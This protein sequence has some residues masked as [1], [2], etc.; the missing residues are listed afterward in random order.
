MQAGS[1]VTLT[2][3]RSGRC[4]IVLEDPSVSRMHAEAT[5][6][7]NGRVFVID[8]NSSQGTFLDRGQGP[9][10]ITQQFVTLDDVVFF[11][12]ARM[13]GSELLEQGRRRS[14]MAPHPEPPP[15]ESD[16]H[17]RPRWDSERGEIRDADSRHPR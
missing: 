11:G 2:I 17:G 13:S 7:S 15:R 16:R 3:G 12:D 9:E 14:A 1:R 10:P 5:V 8:R 6:T 4:S